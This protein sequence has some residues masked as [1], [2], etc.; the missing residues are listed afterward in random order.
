MISNHCSIV[1]TFPSLLFS[2]S[3]NDLKNIYPTTRRPFKYFAEIKP[4]NQLH[5]GQYEHHCQVGKSGTEHWL[6]KSHQD[7]H[8]LSYQGSPPKNREKILLHTKY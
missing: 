7:I 1:K 2:I 8:Y 6:P 4:G 5:Y 3:V